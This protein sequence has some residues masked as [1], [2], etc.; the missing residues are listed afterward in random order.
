MT[1]NDPTAGPAQTYGQPSGS[2]GVGHDSANAWSPDQ[3]ARLE[4]E[5]RRLQRAFAYHPYVTLT[6]L[7]GDP[8]AEYQ[9]DYRVTTLVVDEQNELQYTTAAPVHIWLPAGFPDQPP[10]VR[11]RTALFHPNV[12][13][14]GIYL[15]NAWHP[16]ETLLNLVRKI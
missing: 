13:W 2:P 6:P 5:W 14:E 15:T 7:R 3:L 16:S 11:P 8:P 10:L 1:W 12:S 4:S 9:V